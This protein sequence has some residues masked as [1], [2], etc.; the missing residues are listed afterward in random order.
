M[1]EDDEV[2]VK[3]PEWSRW[4]DPIPEGHVF[5]LNKAIYGNKQAARR[6]HRKIST[7]MEDNGYPAVNSEKT[8]FM[9]RVDDDFI[10]H[11]L[12]VDDI[13]SVP[14]KK[15]LLDEFLAKYS[16]E[17]E[18]TGGKPMDRF[19]GL[20]VEQSKEDI[21]LHLDAYMA[22]TL[23]EYQKM[24]NRTIRP[25]NTPMQ[26]GNVLHP[27]DSPLVLDPKRQAIYRSMVARLQYAATWV[28][29]DISYTVAQLARF[30]ASAGPSHWAALHH[31]MEYLTN[32]PSLKL[33]YPKQPKK[34]MGLEGFCDSDWGNSSSRRSTTGIIFRYD[35]APIY[36]KSKL[37]KT[38]A[39]S[40]AEAEYYAASVG[41][42]ETIYLRR[43]LENMGFTERSWTPLYEDNNACIEWANNMIGGRERAKH[44]DL[45]KHFAHEK[46]QEGHI[47]MLRVDTSE[48]LAD[49]FTKSLQ[50]PTFAVLK[51]GI[52]RRNWSS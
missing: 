18:I 1:T 22:E 10:I 31:V 34:A 40:T 23:E 45:R 37:Q 8:I 26:P 47:R 46:I 36:W 9:K 48:Q 3:P 33:T 20:S 44:I 24:V 25:K 29:F 11:G 12:F 7:W 38:I 13:K 52:L 27:E 14:T 43:L 41:A 42:S 32:Q 35:G 4:F 30:C 15:Y 5:R 2:Y 6:W 19:L 50:P 21:S 49:V 28:R 51:P 17:F 39:L 16:R